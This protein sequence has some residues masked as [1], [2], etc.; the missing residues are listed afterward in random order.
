MS[1]EVQPSLWESTP[2]VGVIATTPPPAGVAARHPLRVS[3]TAHQLP[4]GQHLAKSGRRWRAFWQV[5]DA[6]GRTR[7]RLMNCAEPR[8]WKPT[9]SDTYA[10][11]LVGQWLLLDGTL[12]SGDQDELDQWLR[13]HPAAS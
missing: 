11:A 13:F 4:R 9:S 6:E 10:G 8:Y 7:R 1:S 5:V 12:T 2:V 3:K